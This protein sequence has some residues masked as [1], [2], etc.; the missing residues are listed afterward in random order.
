MDSPKR[1]A[2]IIP[3]TDPKQNL[4]RDHSLVIFHMSAQ[5]GT[6]LPSP[7]DILW[8]TTNHLPN[9]ML[10]EK[11]LPSTPCQLRPRKSHDSSKGYSRP[12]DSIGDYKHYPSAQLW[13][14]IM[15]AWS[16]SATIW[17]SHCPW[18]IL[19]QSSGR[20]SSSMQGTNMRTRTHCVS[21][22]STS[23]GNWLPRNAS[24][25]VLQNL[26]Y[27]EASPFQP[28]T[29]RR[30]DVTTATLVYGCL[31]A[32]WGDAVFIPSKRFSPFASLS[33]IQVDALAPRKPHAARLHPASGASTARQTGAGYAVVRVNAWR[34][35]TS[36]P[37]GI[38]HK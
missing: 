13:S 3:H 17:V 38:M 11:C 22:S 1:K 16:W 12:S 10:R 7:H 4:K 20:L 6:L 5:V 15:W 27:K 29:R 24:L 34:V 14:Q 23:W 21:S 30:L 19:K 28:G 2:N 36:L 31:A 35:S 37:K 25:I 33:Y 26:S 32:S 18:S 8:N 9:T